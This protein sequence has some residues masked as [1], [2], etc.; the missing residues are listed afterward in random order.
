[1]KQRTLR[2]QGLEPRALLAVDVFL[3]I[4]SGEL[5]ITGTPGDDMVSVS[6]DLLSVDVTESPNGD[7]DTLSFPRSAVRSITFRGGDGDDEFTNKVS[8]PSSIFGQGGDDA[9]TGG[10]TMD[11]LQGGE[12]DDQLRGGA[13]VD[14]LVGGAGID[15]LFGDDG[16]DRLEGEEGEDLLHGG[17]GADFLQGGFGVDQLFGDEDDDNLFGGED[18]DYL[19]GGLG[20]DILRGG[21]TRDV[22][23]G[24]EGN[25]QLFG[26]GGSD[27][28]RGDEG[29]DTLIGDVGNDQLSGGLGD[30]ILDGGSGDDTL[31]GDENDDLLIGRE[32]D[33][34]LYGGVGHDDLRGD[35][36]NNRLWG[37]DGN[38][39][40]TGGP[41]NDEL[42]GGA[43]ND[44][45]RGSS[46]SDRLWGDSGFDI[47]RGDDG[48]DVIDGG[49]ERDE[50][51]GGAGNDQLLGDEGDDW[52]IGDEGNDLISGG[53]GSD[54]AWGG[55]G[56]D[57][58]YGGD[59]DDALNGE[60]SADVLRGEA[61]N[62]E[63]LG[64]GGGDNI[65][66]GD[67]NDQVNGGDG[68]DEVF[69]GQGNDV[70]RGGWG[71][72]HVRGLD[73]DDEL[74][75]DQDADIVVGGD[76]DDLL[77]GGAAADLLIGGQGADNLWG[78]DGGDLLVGGVTIYD[79]T[80]ASLRAILRAWSG[81]LEF[82]ETTEVL[83]LGAASPSLRPFE[84]VLDDDEADWLEGDDDRDWFFWFSADTMA[85]RRNDESVTGGDVSSTA[86]FKRMHLDLLARLPTIGEQQL[87]DARIDLGL[88]RGDI[89]LGILRGD[90]YRANEIRYVYR[91]T[92]GREIEPE[93][94]I[95]KLASWG[96]LGSR[97][98][99][100]ANLLG[101]AEFFAAHGNDD[102]RAVQAMFNVVL[103]RTASDAEL[104]VWLELLADG[105][106]SD[107]AY[108]LLVSDEAQA[109][110]L[111]QW[112]REYLH[113]APD[114]AE[115][116]FWARRLDAGMTSIQVQ[117]LL[118]SGAEYVNQPYFAATDFG[119]TPNDATDDSLAIQAALDI[120]GLSGNS[121]IYLAEGVY[122]AENLRLHDSHLKLIGPGT[123]KLKD[124][125][126]AVGVLTVEGNDNL[127]S[128]LRIDGNAAGRPTGRAEGLRVIGNFNRIYRVEAFDTWFDMQAEPVGTNFMIGGANNTLIET[129][130]YNAGHSSYRQVGVANLYRDIVGINAR[131]KGFNGMGE[132]SSFTV[133]GGYFETNATQH[134]LGVN[135]FQVDPG[136]G[137]FVERVV[138]RNV[139]AKGPENSGPITTNV[140]KF[141]LVKE[142][143][144]ENS[145][146]THR[147]EH[148]YSLRFAEGIDTVLLRN[149]FMSRAMYME[150]DLHDGSG[151]QDPVNELIMD[152]VTIGDGVHR[153]PFSMEETEIGRLIVKNSR[154]IG[155]VVAAI[156]WE[157]PEAEY[158]RIEVTDTLF[159]GW[160]ANRVT[161]DI[162][163]DDGGALST[164]AK[165]YWSNIR[166]RNGAGG[167]ALMMP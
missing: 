96:S 14:R 117:S 140:A 133:D 158:S 65:N 111:N 54:N 143:V 64:G 157:T 23:R 8:L 28:L 141:A 116:D 57:E 11:L 90:E 107:V 151:L 146:F 110:R 81:P 93:E 10:P 144:I 102:A 161:Y 121:V 119:A 7:P 122:I 19:Y 159:R 67:G 101:S 48:N 160:N 52:L 26:D 147:A 76:G 145:S 46:G 22:L 18:R 165:R 4:L 55:P 56:A 99:V 49:R 5:R 125:S 1:M 42:R 38:D 88:T 126:T 33:D 91:Q 155:Y 123:L 77:F 68:D 47:L 16:D 153:P 112:F 15:E 118:L 45:L 78:S 138:L 89:A 98:G 129:R 137:K 87:I 104:N 136:P 74:Y 163:P 115:L 83:L 152:R 66:G 50:I 6:A 82:Q 100:W 61:G 31:N 3:D 51:Y 130:A 36:G 127:V 120:A 24:N 21:D 29:N 69:G 135:S 70:V 139:I 162:L 164:P 149:V 71:M 128:Y 35:D 73:G 131:V 85:D 44:I 154:F 156:D 108:D 32:G 150:Q 86:L 124:R 30:D 63:L 41:L 134:P 84:T 17:R 113:R 80:A 72:D 106:R 148:I 43:G 53:D 97:E 58:L 13:G 40:L 9:L 103:R 114:D 39:A 109:T 25:D 166:R 37:D 132:G 59:D 2:V 27:S 95:L 34:L 94:L 62:D 20:N 75:G 60:E 167:G 92:F 12:G 142:I 105:T 79:D